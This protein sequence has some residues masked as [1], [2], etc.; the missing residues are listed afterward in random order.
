MDL[1]EYVYMYLCNLFLDAST[2]THFIVFKK[3]TSVN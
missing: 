2:S 1:Y 3:I